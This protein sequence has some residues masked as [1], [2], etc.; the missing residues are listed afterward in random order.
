MTMTIDRGPLD[1]A[2]GERY[3]GAA[4]LSNIEV[5]GDGQVVVDLVY[6]GTGIEVV[7][8][9]SEV[10]VDDAE[11]A[12]LRWRVETKAIR[13]Q[14]ADPTA[15]DVE[16]IA[17]IG[18]ERNGAYELLVSGRFLLLRKPVAQLADGAQIDTVPITGG[19]VR[20]VVRPALTQNPL[21][22]IDSFP[23]RTL[24]GS[25]QSSEELDGATHLVVAVPPGAT[26]EELQLRVI[27]AR[28]G[29]AVPLR[30]IFYEPVLQAVAGRSAVADGEGVVSLFGRGLVPI[31]FDSTGQERLDFSRVEIRV[32][33]GGR[34]TLLALQSIVQN[35][36]TDNAL[37]VRLPASPDGFPGLVAVDYRVRVPSSFGGEQVVSAI[38]QNAFAYAA[39]S[40]SFEPRGL[41]LDAVPRDIN[42]GVLTTPG[43]GGPTDVAALYGSGFDFVG[44]VRVSKAMGNGMFHRIGDFA[45]SGVP[46]ESTVLVPAGLCLGDF[47]GDSYSDV[48]VLN[49]GTGGG[50]PL[51]TLIENGADRQGILG[52]FGAG[53]VIENQQI[54]E[55]IFQVNLTGDDDDI[56]VATT[57][58]TSFALR[59]DAYSPKYVTQTLQ[60]QFPPSI[61]DADAVF[62]VSRPIDV[63]DDGL[64]EVCFVVRPPLTQSFELS[65]AWFEN[66]LIT[67]TT[68][69]DI[70][71]MLGGYQ[72]QDVLD[73]SGPNRRQIAFVMQPPPVPEG[74]PYRILVF[75]VMPDFSVQ[76]GPML[77]IPAGE[78]N[79][80]AS[81]TRFATELDGDAN[82]EILISAAEDTFQ[83]YDV[84]PTEIVLQR[85]FFEF[86]G[87]P[88]GAVHSIQRGFVDDSTEAIFVTHSSKVSN[89]NTEPR[90]TTLL[91]DELGELASPKA[92][93]QLTRSPVK[94]VGASIGS[95][96]I[97]AA[98]SDGFELLVP[99]KFGTLT[100]QGTVNAQGLLP[101]TVSRV[102]L[103][104]QDALA[105]LTLDGFVGVYV[106]GA[107]SAVYSSMPIFPPDVVGTALVQSS[108]TITCGDLNGDGLDDLI[109]GL[110]YKDDD[111]DVGDEQKGFVIALLGLDDPVGYPW[112]MMPEPIASARVLVRSVAAGRFDLDNRDE[113]AVAE[114]EGVRFYRLSADGERLVAAELD[115]TMPRVGVGKEPDIVR[116]IDLGGDDG[117]DLVMLSLSSSTVSFYLQQ[118]SRF[119]GVNVGGYL[120]ADEDFAISGRAGLLEV[121]DI[122]GDGISDVIISVTD[123][124]GRPLLAAALWDGTD[125]VRR[126]VAVSWRRIGTVDPATLIEEL[127][128]FSLGVADTNGDAISDLVIGWGYDCLDED[129]G[130]DPAPPF[131]QTLFGSRR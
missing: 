58:D 27:D 59:S 97:A 34:E 16:T 83:I 77:E 56:M 80:E 100:G 24:P 123:T 23:N 102:S 117:D 81:V 128:C 106:D 99:D 115:P 28:A 125:R 69:V 86:D 63:D 107:A 11:G 54:P 26:P 90:V 87:E 105:F 51:A 72:P 95:A 112:E 76:I 6:T 1:I 9:Q 62:E 30:G 12:T 46:G 120:L 36:S 94:L 74:L 73:L 71:G 57:W 88:I 17:R 131:V 98:Y 129:P 101:S 14:F 21:V 89:T 38:R 41:A 126:P 7:Q 29:R 25:I 48:M 110:R 2:E 31:E 13:D 8:R 66:G 108:S 85:E 65:F 103:F 116:A 121:A 37:R 22:Q 119:D 64:D 61:Q 5:P 113:I 122:D 49:V 93:M 45:E 43:P 79:A 35:E 44:R 50:A 60:T 18:I 39:N 91:I 53:L 47:G 84:G 52:G 78:E 104:G 15:Q 4:V 114:L 32:S 82:A 20:L 127:R 92:R 40:P 111:P 70:T 96:R 19:T 109:V 33:R 68:P 124:L 130:S 75:D 42:F 55:R 10:V 3:E 118:E 67:G